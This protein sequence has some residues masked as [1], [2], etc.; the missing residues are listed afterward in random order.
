M[1]STRIV[2]V[3]RPIT[4]GLRRVHRMGSGP[5]SRALLRSVAV[6]LCLCAISSNLAC[7]KSRSPTDPGSANCGIYPD[8][9][10]SPYVLPYPVGSSHQV[11]QGNCGSFSHQANSVNQFGYDFAMRLGTEVTATRGGTVVVAIE[12][13]PENTGQYG[14]ENIVVVDHGDGTYGRYLHFQTQGA[15][16]DV[17]DAVSPGDPVG[18]VGLSG[19][20]VGPH[21]HFD[22]SMG[23]YE[24]EPRCPTVPVTFR[25]TSPHPNGLEEGRSYQAVPYS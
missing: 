16:V 18:L 15:L 10:S 5:F 6:V 19:F 22:V 14:D 4:F 13:R 3:L 12:H 11:I 7:N 21:L 23:C 9:A 17:G 1:S 2:K 24:Y 20:T 8:Q 25:N